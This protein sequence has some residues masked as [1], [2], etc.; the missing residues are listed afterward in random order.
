MIFLMHGFIGSGKTTKAR[1]LEVTTKAI[2]F[3]P[4]EWMLKLYGVNPPEGL[5]GEYLNRIFQVMENVWITLAKNE[6]N[7]IL[8]YG[9]WTKKS[10]DEIVAKLEH[11]CFEYT[12]VVLDTEIEE[13]RMRN[14]LRSVSTDKTI[15]ISDE[16]FDWL[17][18]QF[19]PMGNSQRE[20]LLI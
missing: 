6:V 1:E 2:R 15:E 17:K 9:F 13:C 8:D 20:M 11:Q 4:D 10:R 5:F 12:W 7:V 16:T 19:E 14:T 18:Q 3:T